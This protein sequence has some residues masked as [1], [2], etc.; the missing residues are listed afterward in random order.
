MTYDVEPVVVPL[1]RNDH[2]V[3]RVGGTR[4][5]L[6]SVLSAHLQGESPDGIVERFPTL[7]P[8]DVHATLAWYLRYRDE[9]D[10]YL[11][12]IRS[13]FDAGR[14]EAAHRNAGALTRARLL[15]RTAE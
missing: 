1:R 5:T 8:A 12:E 3:L 10:A 9:A 2:G 7:H 6:E 11:A 14:R 13:R 4:V 15:A